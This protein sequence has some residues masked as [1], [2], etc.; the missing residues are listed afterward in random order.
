ME[1]LD[2]RRYPKNLGR[3]LLSS[4]EFFLSRY[5]SNRLQ[6]EPIYLFT[7]AFVSS[8]RIKYNFQKN[9]I[10]IFLSTLFK[11]S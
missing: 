6:R 8:R 3:V 2:T 11:N 4:I 9:L 5:K 10:P 1:K 7:Y